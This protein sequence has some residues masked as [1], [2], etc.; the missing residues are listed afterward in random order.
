[1][2]PL[3]PSS[4]TNPFAVDDP[5]IRAAWSALLPAGLVL[6]LCLASIPLPALV[7]KHLFNPA[8]PFLTLEEA[9]ALSG[10]SPS[11]EEVASQSGSKWTATVLASLA[12]VQILLWIGVGVAE[13]ASNALGLGRILPFLF[14]I[15][16]GYAF[17]RPLVK[18]P[19]IT[20]P[21]DLFWLF[22]LE[23]SGAVLL[24]GGVLLGF[25]TVPRNTTAIFVC[26][27]ILTTC[28]L[29][30]VLRLPLAV[31]I[32]QPLPDELEPA[33]EDYTS[34]FHWITFAWVY[35]LIRRGT[36]DTLAEK[37]VWDL[38]PT[39][40]ARPVFYKFT[41]L[42]Y[43]ISQENFSSFSS[44]T[45]RSSLLRT[46]I[47]AHFSD[48][49][50]DASLSVLSVFLNFSGPFF[51][52]LILAT[53]E[54]E[55]PREG[56]RRLAYL[57][58][59]LAFA[60]Q[61][62]K[63]ESN[64]MRFFYSRR[65]STRM[66]TELMVAIYEK[67]LKRCDFTGIVDAEAQAEAKATKDAKTGKKDGKTDAPA[68][69]QDNDTLGPKAGAQLGKIV[70]L[71]SV[72]TNTV[73]TIPI[74]MFFLY[75]APFEIAISV[76]FLYRLLGWASFSG[77]V[78]VILSIPLNYFIAKLNVKY[79]K[80]IV[81]ARDKRTS[82]V[83]ELISSIKFIKFGGAE[84]RWLKK[85]NGA[86]DVEL[87]WLWKS[88]VVQLAFYLTWL[89]LPLSI[90][91]SAFYVYIKQ[92]NDLTVAT[93]FTALSIFNML[94]LPLSVVP[95]MISELLQAGVALSRISKFLEEDEV[96]DGVS[97]LK[98]QPAEDDSATSGLVI[99]NGSFKWNELA[100]DDQSKPPEAETS[101][102]E[103]RFELRDISVSF[104]EGKL[105]CVVGPTASGKTALLQALLGEMTCLPGTQIRPPKSAKVDE[106]GLMH[107]MSYSAQT[108]WLQYASIKE[109]IIFGF[110]LDE[111]RYQNVLEACALLP[112][113][114][115]LPD[116]DRTEIGVRGVTLSGGQKARVAL[117]RAVYAWTKYVLLDDPLSAVDSHTSRILFEKLFCGP[118]LK[119]RTVVLVTH[120]IDLLLSGNEGSGAHYLV[121]MLDG[122][123]DA[124]GTVQ[125]LRARGL[126]EAIKHDLKNESPSEASAAEA[127]EDRAEAKPTS[128]ESVT[129]LVED[130]E[131]A[132]GE[133]EWR[134]YK[135][136]LKA[137]GYSIWG[138]TGLFV[139]TIE[140][141]D[142]GQKFWIKI[143]GEA[144][145]ATS[146][147]EYFSSVSF[148]G[149]HQAVL[150][151]LP[152]ST[153][154][155]SAFDFP[156]AYDNP[157]FYVVIYT[158]IGLFSALLRLALDAVQLYGAFRASRSLFRELLNKLVYSTF[159]WF[160]STPKGRILNRTGKD[161]S[162]IDMNISMSMYNLLHILA[163][164]GVAILTVGVV[165]P[166][167][168]IP[169]LLLSFAYYKLS[170]GYLH[171]S[172]DL[173]RMEANTRSPIF[174]GFS[175]LLEGI[176]TVRAFGVEKRFLQSMY[177]MVDRTTRLGYS[178]WQA[179]RWLLLN[180]DYLGASAVLFTSLISVSAFVPAGL[181]GICITS[182]M[183]FS[184]MSYYACRFY[185][186]LQVDL[187]A[188][189]RVVNYLEIPQEP[190][191]VIESNR[192][193]AYW[194]SS[195]SNTDL[196]VVEDLEVKY[197]PN[198]PSVLHR[199]SFALKARE[200]VGILGRTGSGKSTLATSLLRFVEPTNG[201]IIV[202]GIDI[203]T[204]GLNDLRT[205][206]TFIPQDAT[207]FSG[208]IRENLD[209][210]DEYE[211]A[212][213][214]AVL[215]RV[216]LHQN[217]SAHQSRRTS[218]RGSPV[219][220]LEAD[221]EAA[222]VSGVSSVTEVDSKPVISLDSMV[223]AEGTNFSHGQRQLIALARA[224]LRQSSIII[225]DEAT[226]SIDFET[227]RK[228]QKTIREEFTDSLLVTIAHRINSV[229]DYDRLIIL[230][231]GKIAQFD[232]PY[233]L[234]QSE[235][236]FR[237]MCKKTGAFSEL[238]AAAMGASQRL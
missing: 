228:I 179:N 128:V 81:N 154:L 166:S 121:R 68:A 178:F 40:Q 196:L 188:V 50:L 86:R 159:R 48:F 82:V 199:I 205:R 78:F 2:V 185:T 14:A 224:L 176:V 8:Q 21:M 193:P 80:G 204:I 76:V 220:E 45:R 216:H 231:Q 213:L 140:L 105:T 187:N 142:L 51:M 169:G 170:V 18:N 145:R 67:A 189:E 234:I 65:A 56:D 70:N 13:V 173:R 164:L 23:F 191:A 57:Y 172:R 146:V 184:Q 132:K 217:Q 122:R 174:T 93:A 165:F 123:I 62:A 162:T 218:A 66:K 139:I 237:D 17:L 109:N 74:Q 64:V 227:D 208:T 137:S 108:P 91:V 110:P 12:L 177:G 52:N 44:S 157:M 20:A 103:T 6:L 107:C 42:K 180:F 203:S 235:G 38:S 133:V 138:I 127:K 4:E 61:I 195:S 39:M 118:L 15:S 214:E 100:K 25:G 120:H 201:R 225:L 222:S 151:L 102:E 34:L 72:D 59:L 125:D 155:A 98:L 236:I 63:S 175:E 150:N 88:R 106:N 211:E 131:Q 130:E 135:T 186:I 183:S 3:C 49:L 182:A 114:A 223:S 161:I 5:C 197:A 73:T 36:N 215:F 163:A 219:A 144:Y 55:H 153:P 111:E 94:N 101:I 233:N 96:S 60:C 31:P 158:L 238:E 209:P 27:V 24:L 90:S 202:D 10:A 22:F 126:L 147:L 29:V 95:F 83:N 9:E 84:E 89:L 11:D 206:L 26:N 152:T 226:S 134:I 167:F 69:S 210:F 35:P 124:Q 47:R 232:T 212:E 149:A 16:W 77:I 168:L 41:Q 198:L 79:E 192:P 58:A 160:D 119:D 97:A 115:I 116:G 7:K 190:P 28:L 33:P 171:S 46:I 85:V 37:D 87:G 221:T 32:R 194:P 54:L 53:L 112:D 19:I 75:S 143:W 141:V 71:M 230:D 104:P 30:V 1:M 181:A 43:C 207:L 113:L 136:Y 92:G 129:K 200:R 229:I 148:Q 117:A 156:S 99:E